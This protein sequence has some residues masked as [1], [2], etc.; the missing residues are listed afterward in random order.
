VV[1]WKVINDLRTLSAPDDACARAQGRS[2][3][4]VILSARFAHAQVD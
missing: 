2:E 3:S 4:G 1:P